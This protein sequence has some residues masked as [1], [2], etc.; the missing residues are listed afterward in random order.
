MKLT[1]LRFIDPAT[2]PAKR[3]RSSALV[4]Q[5]VADLQKIPKGQVQALE[6][7]VPDIKKWASYQL[8]KAL[9]KRVKNV[10][11]SQRENK[12]YVVV[13]DKGTTPPTGGHKGNR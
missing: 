10:E 11:V 13:V 8:G 4:E 9:A 5:V 3:A 12:V 7:T 1:S 6:Y 2:I